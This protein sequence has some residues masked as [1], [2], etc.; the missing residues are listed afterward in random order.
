[1]YQDW[2]AIGFSD[3]GELTGA[4]LCVFWDD[5]DGRKILTVRMGRYILYIP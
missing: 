4:D 1:M 2:I 5:G 3:R